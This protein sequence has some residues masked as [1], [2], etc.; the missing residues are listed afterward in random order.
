VVNRGDSLP[1]KII[2]LD[3]DGVI[4]KKAAECG[5]ITR[6]ADFHL[7]PGVVAAIRLLN[8]AGYK[9]AVVTNQRCVALGLLTCRELEDLHDKMRSELIKKGAYVSWVFYCP[10]DRGVCECRKPGIALLC[11]VEQY[12]SV[13][14]TASWMI[15]DSASDIE[16]GNS[17]GVKTIFIG[18]TNSDAFFCCDSLIEAVKFIVE[19]RA[20]NTESQIEVFPF[21]YI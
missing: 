5:Y 7:L 21:P 1:E 3:R 16:A 6:W 17:Y 10:H 2:F 11:K 9:I 19:N 18:E 13:D 8:N 12:V 15:G 14:K 4:N 20:C